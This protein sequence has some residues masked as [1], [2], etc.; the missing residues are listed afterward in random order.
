MKFYERLEICA[1]KLRSK[2][3]YHELKYYVDRKTPHIRTFY[4][5]NGRAIG[6]TYNLMKISGKYRIPVLEPIG[7]AR[8]LLP[9]VYKKFNPIVVN[10]EELR[11]GYK[12]GSIV[13]VD[14]R[15]LLNN[16]AKEILKDYIQIG[17]E[18]ENN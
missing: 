15:Q 14:E 6:K 11:V 4:K 2:A 10:S 18:M 5:W 8:Q 7:M 17:F 3:L 9:R 12:P 1:F 13:L 16:R